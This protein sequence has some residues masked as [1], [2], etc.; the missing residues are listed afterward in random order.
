MKTLSIVVPCYNSADYVRRCL[1]SLVMGGADVEILVIN[2]GS[3]DHTGLIAEEYQARFPG[4]VRAIH[5]PNGG[6]GSAINTG[7][8]EAIGRHIKIV[9]SDDW[10]DAEAYSAV[11]R[12]LK[13]FASTGTEIDALLSNFVYEKAGRRTGHV[14]RY[15]GALPR[16]RV[17]GWH[18]VGRFRPTQYILMHSLIYRS[19]LLRECGLRLPEHTF[20]VDNLYAFVPLPHVKTLFYLDVDFYRYFIG[21][22]DQSVNENVMMRR[23]DQQIKVNQLM[24]EHLPAIGGVPLQLNSY[25]LHYFSIICGVTSMMLIRSGT[26]E[27]FAARDAFWS[28][29]RTEQPRLHRRM[30]RRPVAQITNLPGRA[31]RGVSVFAYLLMRRVVGF[32]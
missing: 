18:E 32:N 12:A 21:R 5:K 22:D 29:L 14:V 3:T 16:G 26:P 2:D 13:G 17:F 15:R 23:L 8:D 28:S 11:L 30:R 7:I 25:L 6:H 4:M 31:G 19:E 1:D 9:D 24:Q 10:V 20:Y 27:S